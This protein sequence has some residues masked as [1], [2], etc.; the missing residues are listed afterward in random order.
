MEPVLLIF[1]FLISLVANLTFAIPFINFLYR[2]KFYK[3]KVTSGVDTSKRN[4]LY[5]KHLG[6]TMSKPSSFGAMV[7]LNILIFLLV[8]NKLSY[9][10]KYII[11]F[12][13]IFLLFGLVDDYLKYFYYLKTSRW[14]LTTRSKLFIQLALVFLSLIF[15][16]NVWWLLLLFFLI[17]EIT[18][19]IN[20]YNITDGLDGFVGSL[21]LLILPVLTY[22]EY[23]TINDSNLIY[24]Y[25]VL[26][27][28][29]VVF[30]YFNI[31]PAR[32]I[33]GD[34]GSMGI[35]FLL[36]ILT[37]RYASIPMLI[38]YSIFIIEGLSSLIQILSIRLF[39][40]KVFLIA[41]LHLNFMNRGWEDTKIVQRSTLV[42]IIL[43][44]L[45]ILAFELNV[46][47]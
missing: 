46:W 36:G 30:L 40:R 45:S 15:I 28:F 43:C 44:C 1:I 17:L 5:Y 39:K 21:T 20:S 34:V 19:I 7:I 25:A 41:P 32:V 47:K 27:G 37:L 9:G 33:F 8:F 29:F 6:E 42:Q 14:G 13:L 4:P 2:N 3:T 12:T 16:A 38:L 24:F 23:R 18:F 10:V 31:K 35:G 26:F 22:F 11:I